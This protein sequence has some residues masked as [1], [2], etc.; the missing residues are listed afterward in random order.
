MRERVRHDITLPFLLQPIVPDCAGG[1][2]RL[3]DITLLQQTFLLRIVRPNTC[4]KICL[5][6]EPN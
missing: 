1:I 5:Q 2:K 4:Q 6:F 3:L